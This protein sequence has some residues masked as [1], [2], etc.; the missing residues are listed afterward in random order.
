[1]DRIEILTIGDELIEGR[2]VDTNAGWMSQRLTDA[3]LRIAGHR[4]VGD[5]PGDIEHA[6]RSAASTAAAVLVSG[7]LGP[8]TDDLTA[9]CAAAAA[10]VATVSHPEALAHV[11]AFFA[12]RGRPMSAN[13]AQQADLPVGC[14][15]LPNPNG[16]AVGFRL[17]IEGTPCFFMPGVPREL[18]SM[19]DDHV[20]PDLQSR[21]VADPPLT[22]ELKL[23]GLGESDVGQR[24]EDLGAGLAPPA[25]LL[26]QY[27]AT[28]PEIHVRLGLRR[29]DTAGMATVVDEARS[30]LGDHVF[31]WGPAPCGDTLAEMVIAGLRRAGATVAVAEGLTAGH[32]AALLLDAAGAEEI[33]AGG[34]INSF[35]STVAAERAIAVRTQYGATLGVAVTGGATAHDVVLVVDSGDDAPTV[36]EIRFPIDR[37][38]LRI[39]AA[40]AAL[41][42][43]R[44][45]CQS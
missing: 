5:D 30:R 14:T 34:E 40:H 27:R 18:E 11:E 36:R 20:L 22:T 24:L 45:H 41:A 29:S 3:G 28:F 21:L 44:R 8:T 35:P 37:K 6:L 26:I 4:S 10:G 12:S 13:N 43:V 1:M 38:R 17:E 2:L 25:A 42:L 9:R 33:F 19:F 16:T 39:L 32:I 31:A 15:L 23:F 7:G